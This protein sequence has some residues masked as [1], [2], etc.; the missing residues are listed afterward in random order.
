MKIITTIAFSLLAAGLL[1]AAETNTTDQVSAAITKLKQQ[2]NYTWTTTQ[3]MPGMPFTPEPLHGKIG[4]DGIALV[5][6]S[7]NGND[8]QVAFQS[9]KIAVLTDSQWTAVTTNQDAGDMGNSRL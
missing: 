1:T 8:T 6:Q 3:Q 9:D 4:N 5:T 2:P 7:F